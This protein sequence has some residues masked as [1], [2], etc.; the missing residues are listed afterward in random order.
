M[1]VVP[2]ML[3]EAAAKQLTDIPLSDTTISPR[4]LD[5]VEDIIDQLIDKLKDKNF[6]L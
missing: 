6:S 3:G 5:L 1:G 4:I 2:V